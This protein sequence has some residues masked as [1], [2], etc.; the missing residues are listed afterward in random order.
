MK[1][2][3]NITKKCKDASEMVNMDNLYKKLKAYELDGCEIFY[4]ITHDDKL[5]LS[6]SCK[7]GLPSTDIMVE[8]FRQL[9]NKDI[10]N[11][12]IMCSEKVLYFME[13]DSHVLDRL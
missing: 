13:K 9:T 12:D 2:V 10:S 5:H 8:A 1:K 7:N 6:G 4:C 3:K 11:F